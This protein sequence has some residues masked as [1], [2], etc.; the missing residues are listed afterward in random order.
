MG[1]KYLDDD[2]QSKYIKEMSIV[3]FF[4][5]KASGDLIPPF[6]TMTIPLALKTTT[7]TDGR[8]HRCAEVEHYNY[9]NCIV[10]ISDDTRYSSL[11]KII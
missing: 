1:K 5:K 4:G 3:V 6:K 10:D 11:Q 8:K 7:T 9:N 2:I